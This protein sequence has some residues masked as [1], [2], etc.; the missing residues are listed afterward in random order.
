LVAQA[1]S[2][3][4]THLVLT[5]TN[6]LYGR[7]SFSRLSGVFGE[8]AFLTLERHGQGN[9]EDEVCGEI[10]ILLARVGMPAV[11]V[12]PIFWMHPKER[13]RLH[14]LAAIDLRQF[15]DCIYA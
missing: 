6:A 9:H 4:L 14:L 12:Q 10:L 2:D 3:G 8:G 13:S 15:Q 11:A 7:V 1:V 5:D